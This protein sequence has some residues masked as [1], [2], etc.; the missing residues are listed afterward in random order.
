MEGFETEL[1]AYVHQAVHEA[2]QEIER[3]INRPQLLT[4]KYLNTIEAAKFLSKTPNA[5]RQIVF[6]E[7]I[8]YIRKGNRLHFRESDLIEYLESGGGTGKG[9]QTNDLLMRKGGFK[10]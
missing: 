9:E 3:G 7:Q 10:V 2:L 4:G 8:K 6:K 1:K 5:V